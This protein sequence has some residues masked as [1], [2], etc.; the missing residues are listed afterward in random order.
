MPCEGI[1]FGAASEDGF[2]LQVLALRQGVEVSQD[3]SG[4]RAR[5]RRTGRRCGRGCAKR[6][7]VGTDGSIAAGVA[8]RLD[9]LP[10]SPGVR[11]ALGPSLVQ[12]G[13]EVVELGLAVLPL[14]PGT[15]PPASRRRPAV[16]RCGR[17]CRAGAGS[18][19]GCGQ[20]P[21]AHGQRRAWRGYG[22]RTGARW[23]MATRSRPVPEPSPA[24]TR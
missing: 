14:P 18:S 5:G 10:E 7:E 19:V 11:A 1:Q 9:L 16:G 6:L 23:A 8:V 20:R 15:G 2:E 22:R 3:P 4:D 21:A 12:V 17:S 24:P 13:L